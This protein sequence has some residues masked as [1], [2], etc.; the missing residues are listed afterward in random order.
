MIAVWFSCGA[1]SAVAAKRTVEKYGATHDIRVINTPI[2]EEDE[3]NRRFL[4]DVEEWIGITIEL[5]TNPKYPTNSAADV[6]IDRQ[7]M[8]GIKG[9]PCTGQLK[10]EAR[11][12]WEEKNKP[13]YH[14]MGFTAD[15]RHRHELFIVTELPNV[16]PVLIDCGHTKDDCYRIVND[17][18][19]VLPRSYR[20]G[21]NNANCKGCVKATSPTYWNHVRVT[22][23]DVFQERSEQ[24][25]S[26]GKNGVRL[27]RYKGKRI[28]LDEL[29]EDAKGRPM[30]KLP[31][32]DCNVFCETPESIRRKLKATKP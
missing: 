27:V 22:D 16:I 8:S 4:K 5:A 24:S 23:P 11:Y 29:P 19:I 26:I 12:I 14:V 3:D 7:Y 25:R 2:K 32:F 20:Q 1:A 30:K 13:D 9:A 15:E 21:Y 31:S 28:F 18:G 17:A 10:K 6:W